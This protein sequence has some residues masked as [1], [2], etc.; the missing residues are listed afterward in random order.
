MK[1]RREVTIEIEREIIISKPHSNWSW[2]YRCGQQ[3]QM[4]TAGEAAQMINSTEAKIY[5]LVESEQL[6][7]TAT[8]QGM[9]LVCP[10]SVIAIGSGDQTIPRELLLITDGEIPNH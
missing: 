9:L 1:R 3:M 7:F 2:C 10:N 8:P 6:H 5:E 4:L